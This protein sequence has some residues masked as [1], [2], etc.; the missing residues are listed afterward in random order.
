MRS[1][2]TLSWMAAFWTATACGQYT[3]ISTGEA[4]RLPQ[5]LPSSA[6]NTTP[7]TPQTGLASP[8][9]ST[10]PSRPGSLMAGLPESVTPYSSYYGP[11]SLPP[12]YPPVYSPAPAQRPMGYQALSNP[13]S[14]YPQSAYAPPA[15]AQAPHT[16]AP[17]QR[18]AAGQPSS[19]RTAQAQRLPPSSASYANNQANRGSGYR[20]PVNPGYYGAAPTAPATPP[21][22]IYNNPRL[23]TPAAA[24]QLQP[25]PSGSPS[26]AVYGGY[27]NGG[28][29]CCGNGGYYGGGFISS[30]F[31]CGVHGRRAPCGTGCF[32]GPVAQYSQAACGPCGD[33]CGDGCD[34]VCGGMWFASVRA[35]YMTR[36]SANSVSTSYNTAN[37]SQELM[38]TQFDTTWQPGGEVRF[39]R[40][41]ACGMVSVEAVY[42]T[43]NPVTGTQSAT[44]ANGTVSTPLRTDGFQ[45]GAGGSPLTGSDF[46][47]RAR[48]H[49]L[50]MRDEIHDV[51]VNLL[52]NPFADPCCG[53]G[54]IKWLIGARFIRFTEDT[55]FGT[56][57]GAG[58]TWGAGGG[59]LEAY[60]DDQVAND[61]MGGQL[62]LDA[63]FCL[64]GTVK[65]VVAP[66]VGIFNNHMEN[67][68]RL[69]RGDGVVATPIA[70]S[71]LPGVYDLSTSKDA[72]AFLGQLDLGVQWNFFCNWSATMGY[73]LVA[74]SGVGLADHQFTNNLVN[75]PGM[76]QI[77][78]NGELI[79]HGAYAGLQ[80]NF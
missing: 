12:V 58:T 15:Y 63:Q 40:S 26:D 18:P 80:Y 5:A 21:P 3:S 11:A 72:L 41:F 60:M 50:S 54:N 30:R 25:V 49:R 13:P 59:A 32:S 16:P 44:V 6:W 69:Y 78:H 47:N 27:E 51:E 45:F 75:N 71:G 66:R 9:A 38:H 65:L 22:M 64:G 4:V 28:P 36:A 61:M 24:P 48:E 10:I 73:R 67:H 53:F 57:S 76:A 20:A 74:I 2:L 17:M 8:S 79:L 29:G 77:D 68:F 55:T 19:Y 14:A 62:G 23:P 56:L 37:P 43:L 46:Y 35:L 34:S 52:T 1:V 7:A 39:G 42:W 31:G 33:V 70:A